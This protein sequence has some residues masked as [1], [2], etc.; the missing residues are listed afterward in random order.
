MYQIIKSALISLFRPS[1][2]L[3]FLSFTEI[4]HTF[5]KKPHPHAKEW[6][7]LEDQAP[8]KK[9]LK[10]KFILSPECDIHFSSL[11]DNQTYICKCRKSEKKDETIQ[12]L[13]LVPLNQ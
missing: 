2:K 13:I 1:Q 12:K 5:E 8:N 9:G 10:Q 4:G 11:K 6:F 3:F 7:C